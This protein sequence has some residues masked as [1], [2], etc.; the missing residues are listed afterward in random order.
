[1]K[2]KEICKKELEQAI[3][4]LTGTE[5]GQI[6]LAWLCAECGFMNNKMHPTDPNATQV[7]ASMRGIYAK[8]RKFIKPQDLIKAEY[9]IIFKEKAND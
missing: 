6:F 5:D 8:I 7:F 1:M 3:N 2:Q 4:R 9:G